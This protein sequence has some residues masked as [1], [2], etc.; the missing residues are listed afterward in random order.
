MTRESEKINIITKLVLLFGPTLGLMCGSALVPNMPAMMSA[1]ESVP[2]ARFWISLIL[3]L[4][5]LFVVI[6][7]PVSGYLTDRVG[8]KK[9]LVSSLLLC[10]LAGTAGYMIHSLGGILATRI[11]VGLGIA[12]AT[13]ASN[14][15]IADYFDGPA[16]ARFMGFQ[17]AIMGFNGIIFMVLGGILADF[18][19]QYSFL[20]YLPLLFLFPF[21]WIF[22]REPGDPGSVV[23]EVPKVK[24]KLNR[25]LTFILVATFLTQF[26]FATM[27]IFLAYYLNE[28]FGAVSTIVGIVGAVASLTSLITGLLYG[29]IRNRM[30]FRDIFLMAAIMLGIGFLF[31]GTAKSWGLVVVA[32]VILGVCMGLNLSNLPTWLADEVGQAI[33]GRANGLY[34]TMMYFGQFTT[35]LIFTPISKITGYGMVY[36]IVACLSVL[37]G[38]GVFF[39]PK[40]TRQLEEANL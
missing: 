16:R 38:L 23:H 24:L 1:F 4:P 29:R 22:I 14:A 21:A 25:K 37:A 9:I 18:N 6:G 33:R 10:G 40:E 2:N 34:V 17:S 31:L 27:P 35:S 30:S 28:L 12:G 7:G 13:T 39:L 26:T 8:R 32:E 3:T 15:L 11:L 20:A 5:A 19:W 36:L